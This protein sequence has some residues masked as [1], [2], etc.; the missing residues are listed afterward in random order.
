[1][2]ASVAVAASGLHAQAAAD[3]AAIGPQNAPHG[4]AE[5]VS[6]AAAPNPLS[7]Q[8]ALSFAQE[9]HPDLAVARA[10]VR[11]LRAESIAANVRPHSPELDAF[12]ERGGE[13][14]A[15]NDAGRFELG[16]TQ[17]IELGKRGARRE[18]AA[19]RLR[20]AEAEL[21][22][23]QQQVEAEVRARFQPAL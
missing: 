5:T 20:T 7:L 21:A 3:R 13:S 4:A 22:A 19:A 14:F 17:E 11:V 10:A 18:L 2:V 8:G 16:L 6:V 12:I 1:L 23:R 15:S 9:H